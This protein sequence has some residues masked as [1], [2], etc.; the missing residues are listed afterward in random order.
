MTQEER[1][2]E[3]FN[4]VK[5][6]IETNHR[7]PSKYHDGEKLMVHFLKRNRKLMNAGELME[8][9]LGWFRELLKLCE[10]YKRVNQW[11]GSLRSGG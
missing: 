9:K 11:R 3:R 7:H 1:W 6:F 8:P 5:S 10:E 2:Q 4:D